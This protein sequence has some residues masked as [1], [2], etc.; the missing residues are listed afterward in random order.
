MNAATQ[1]EITALSLPERAAVALGAAAHEVKLRALLTNSAGILA[2][3]S[4]AGRE[5]CHAAYMVLKNA[6]CSIANLS[7]DATEDAKK[8]TKAVKTEADRLTTITEA[9]EARLL[10]LR[11]R[12]DSEIEA[13][14]K[15]K[16]EAEIERIAAIRARIGALRDFGFDV[17]HG[18]AQQ[19]DDAITRFYDLKPGDD[20]SDADMGQ[21]A[22]TAWGARLH[23]L[24]T[25]RFAAG[26]RE[27]EAAKVEAARIAAAEKF[28][29][30]QEELRVI[31]AAH[32]VKVAELVEAQRLAKVEADRV[33]EL[34]RLNAEKEAAQRQAIQDEMSRREASLRADQAAHAAEVKRADE[35]RAAEVKGWADALA[36]HQAAADARDEAAA[37]ARDDEKRQIAADAEHAEAL[38]DNAVW[39]ADKL[40]ADHAEALLMDLQHDIDRASAVAGVM[41]HV[42]DAGALVDLAGD[43]P[44]DKEIIDAYCAE[45]DAT[46]E[47]AFIRLARMVMDV[48]DQSGDLLRA[49]Q[50]RAEDRAAKA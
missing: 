46:P 50:S 19:I 30:E 37:W 17:T 27:E 18:T 24:Q 4:K 48:I 14:K 12:W 26:Q 25:I 34:A 36:A 10:I 13:E 49:A 5:E 44:T 8:F 35:A 16:I 1:T 47:A 32:A 33:E 40:S 29:C 22:K 6:R 28:Q 21:E 15:A 3:T 41:L 20:W 31:Q 2:I 38:A 39:D 45:F 9:E 11:D 7:N 42:L 43:E 23:Q